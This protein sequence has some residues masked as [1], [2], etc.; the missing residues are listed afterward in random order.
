MKSYPPKPTTLQRNDQDPVPGPSNLNRSIPANLNHSVNKFQA[1]SNGGAGVSLD[2]DYGEDDDEYFDANDGE[3][4]AFSLDD[5]NPDFYDPPAPPLPNPN[6][7][8]RQDPPRR[9][10]DPFRPLLREDR[11][12]RAVQP[13]SGPIPGEDQAEADRPT[14]GL[15]PAYLNDEAP[16]VRLAYLGAVIG[17]VYG[18]LSVV[19]ATD[20]LNNTLDVLSVAGALPDFPRPV[21]TLVS[22]KRRLGIDPDQWVIPYALCPICWKHHSPSQLEK[23]TSPECS[24]SGCKGIIYID[25]EGVKRR[26][27]QTP[28]LICPQVSIIDSLRRMFLRPGFATSLRDSRDEA[29]DKNSYEDF[30]MRDIHDAEAWNDSHTGSARH[31]GENGTIKDMAL[32]GQPP[33]KNLSSHRY[34]L[35]LTMNGDWRVVFSSFFEFLYLF[36]FRFGIFDNRPH[37]AGGIYVVIN[38]LPREMRFLQVNTINYTITPGPSEPNELQ[39]NHVLENA[40]SQVMMLK[41]GS[42]FNGNSLQ[43]AN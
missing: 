16:A 5:M 37:S 27:I 31:I 23:L 42:Y 12:F 36:C 40:V 20:Q 17:H 34:G 35:H 15:P 28:T 9:Q 25:T 21:R 7:S 14:F 2:N 29:I 1:G 10:Q 24:V 26:R 32:E 39:L 18:H 6:P 43:L 22:A 30:V 38:D 13:P 3:P 8:I 41:Q 4:S 19:Q 11:N 33:P